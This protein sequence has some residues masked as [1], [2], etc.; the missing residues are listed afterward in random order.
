MCP[1]CQTEYDDPANRR[2]HAQPNA[3]PVCGPQMQL[4]NSAGQ[5]VNHDI[6]RLLLEGK[7]LAVKGLGAFHLVADATNAQAVA[8]IRRRKKRDAKPFA[9]MVRDVDTCLLYTSRCV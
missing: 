4:F 6:H 2:F 1:S 8:E 5:M 9:V 3:C 7:I